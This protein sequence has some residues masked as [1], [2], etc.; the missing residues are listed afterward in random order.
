MNREHDGIADW[1]INELCDELECDGDEIVERVRRLS[2]KAETYEKAYNALGDEHF[3][4]LTRL[5]KM[6]AEIK[7]ILPDFNCRMFEPYHKLLAALLP[8]EHI[9]TTE[10]KQ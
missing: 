3:V 2:A 1:V 5:C 8:P 6:Q 9:T 7:K 10:A 4:L